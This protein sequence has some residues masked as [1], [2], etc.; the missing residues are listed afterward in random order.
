M[1]VAF[2]ELALRT[3]L[4]IG[5][6]VVGWEGECRSANVV[7]AIISKKMFSITV[8]AFAFEYIVCD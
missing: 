1:R 8:F 7:I 5:T 3:S 6:N 2:E 4:L